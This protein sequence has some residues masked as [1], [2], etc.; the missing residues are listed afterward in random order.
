M[1]H[2]NQKPLH[3]CDL[4]V[5]EKIALLAGR[6]FWNTDSLGGKVFE[7]NLSDGPVGVRKPFPD[8]KGELHD[9]PSIAY[10]SAEVLAQTWDPALA[11]LTGECVADDCIEK[12]VDI[13][14][15]P[16]VNLKR[17]PMCGRN[18]EYFSEDP[19]LAGVFG[20]EYIAGAENRGVGTSLKHFCANNREYGRLYISSEV[21]ERTLRELYLVPFE[22][23]CEANPSTVMCSYNL[24]NGVRMSEHA[25]L[26]RILRSFWRED[27]AI[28]SDWGAVKDRV[29]SLKAGLDLEMPFSEESASALKTAYEKGE[30]SDSDLDECVERLLSL[31][32][33]LQERRGK[34]KVLRTREERLSSAEKVA[35]EGIVLLK[36]TGVLPI[37]N[38][39]SV[40]VTGEETNRYFAG[41]GSARVIPDGEISTLSE[42]LSA[43]LPKSEIVSADVVSQGKMD[44]YRLSYG[45]DVAI[46]VCGSED[47]EGSDRPSMALSENDV[48]FILETAKNN[49]NTVVV[50]RCGAAVDVSAWENRVAAIVSAGYG[51]ER[52][53][54]ALAAVLTGKVDA[55]GRL[56]ETWANGR[57]EYLSEN[58][59]RDHN[60]SLYEEGLR[61]G[62]RDFD[63]RPE[64][65][66]YPFGFGLSYAE[67]SFSDL[68]VSR[69]KG[70]AKVT[71]KV[72]NISK[73]AGS[74]VVQI[75]VREV[76]PCVFRP[77][78]ELK[79]FEKVRLAAGEEREI[80]VFLPRRAFSYYSTAE[81]GWRVHAGTFEVLACKNAR[82]EMLKATID[83]E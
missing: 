74:E 31:L 61:V 77:Y 81:D 6:D 32:Y 40:S 27:G 36:N 30:I 67:F 15:G 51:G 24:V 42:A 34:R 56:A 23:A 55:A 29:A 69:E 45:K 28:V 10:P 53:N 4:S 16:G 38:G 7:A 70:G 22:I 62:Y 3:A 26:Y 54:E 57:E 63:L 46:V 21:D 44:A 59:Y 66:R 5:G 58:A 13:L 41:G 43:L 65:V 18:F 33:K 9:L 76:E 14:L 39:A 78:K 64:A 68:K 12:G 50:L 37:R 8:E 25:K 60:V 49:K 19:L 1:G 2:S 72:K 83:M 75:Y 79:A 11:R 73:R 20:R 47:G 82:D 52:G 17:T 71:L 35:E 48:R 80:T